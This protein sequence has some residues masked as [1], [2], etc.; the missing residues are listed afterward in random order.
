MNKLKYADDTMIIAHSQK[1][2]QE[3]IITVTQERKA[4][5]LTIITGKSATLIFSKS[6]QRR[7][8]P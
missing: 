4:I 6:E 1:K 5:G 2:R 8:R 3:L 7:P